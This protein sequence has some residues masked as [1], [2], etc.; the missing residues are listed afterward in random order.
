MRAH[1]AAGA[2]PR[3][4]KKRPGHSAK[5]RSSLITGVPVAIP[6]GPRPLACR[7]CRAR[8]RAPITPLSDKDY[9]IDHP[10]LSIQKDSK[11]AAR[12]KRKSAT[13]GA[14][15]LFQEKGKRRYWLFKIPISI[16]SASRRIPDP[17]AKHGKRWDVYR[18]WMERTKKGRKKTGARVITASIT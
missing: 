17:A 15:A 10:G 5:L 2:E 11:K 4:H 13:D 8:V 6:N 12:A 3:R 14:A 9:N 1:T 7:H 18:K 16:F